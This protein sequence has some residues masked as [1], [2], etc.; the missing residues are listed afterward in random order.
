M[1]PRCWWA[2]VLLVILGTAL[3]QEK[4]SAPTLTRVYPSGVQVGQAAEITFEGTN[5]DEPTGLTTT[6]PAQWEIL[7]GN[8]PTQLR[9]RVTALP[10]AWLGWHLIHVVTKKGVTNGRLF[11]LD[12]LPQVL[13]TGTP[14]SPEQAQAVAPPCV[15]CGV[16][17]KDH[18]H[19][20]RLSV[21]AG[22]RLSF[23]V[24]GRR[25]GSRLDPQLAL[26]DGSGKRQLAFSDDA[27]GQQKDP[28]LHGVF[29]DAGEVL[30]EL[31]DVRYQGGPEA[32]YRLRIG[33]FPLVSG[34]FPLAVERGKTGEVQFVS[35]QG[36]CVAP[37]VVDTAEILKQ[38]KLSATSFMPV[39]TRGPAH[40]P[41]HPLGL[42]SWPAPLRLSAF[43]E[44]VESGT[45][46]SMSSAHEVPVPSGVSGRFTQ[47]ASKRF[48][49][50]QGKKDQ[51]YLLTVTSHAIGLPTT[52][53]LTLLDNQGRTLATSNPTDDPVHI[54]FK[55]PADGVY[56]VQA[57]HLFDAG[58]ASEIFR[59]EIKPVAP[60]F[61]LEAATDHVNLPSG[62]GAALLVTA[63]R[64]LFDGPIE[65]VATE[66]S[67]V[68][69]TI[70]AGQARTFCWLPATLA[71][72][73]RLQ[74]AGRAVGITEGPLA[75]PRFVQCRQVLRQTHNQLRYWPLHLGY[76]LAVQ[77]TPAP[78][79]TLAARYVYPTAVRGLPV[80]VAVTVTR[81]SGVP[82]ELTLSAETWPVP[83]GQPP[84]LAPLRTKIPAD[85]AEAT[86]E[87]H[88][89]PQA[90]NGL[91]V[92]LTGT[93]AA[94]QSLSVLLPGLRF[95]PPFEVTVA[96]P[97]PLSRAG[98]A[99][100]PPPKPDLLL[101]PGWVPG[102]LMCP[103]AWLDEVFWHRWL[104][105]QPVRIQVE[106]QGGYRG[107]IVL[108]V[109]NLPP[110][111]TVDKVTIPEGANSAWVILRSAS[112]VAA[113]Q[114]P[115]VY[116]QGTATGAGNQQQ[117]SAPFTVLVGGEG[118]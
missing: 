57:E 33:D 56:V 19:W 28:R 76:D 14:H 95:G 15:V 5:L 86:I 116:V 1:L 104:G 10:G 100:A 22:Q 112:D 66:N 98:R 89:T 114:K 6:F 101:W 46:D 32:G 69:G 99:A 68:V 42:P 12:E 83:P 103:A 85:R 3:A 31:R 65:I 72:A 111:V 78:P 24:L 64:E 70:P 50:F 67:Q 53:F 84:L 92:V 63:R 60:D 17:D 37:V 81:S 88:P 80:P 8:S 41:R 55:A 91:E 49:R 107:P 117:R 13:T 30:V 44:M 108:E 118:R 113:A 73:P 79:F 59:L 82:E 25:L 11:C 105:L 52:V 34:P 40:L 36:S 18:S 2:S 7:P 110:G 45:N 21:Q 115:D 96:A 43:P 20:F 58:G 27:P 38:N 39:W 94:G 93:N 77:Q 106:R 62:H 87:L 48:Y 16:L 61:H 51:H 47:P 4:T 54:Q 29:T 109:L 102:L 9:M 75:E 97:P 23:E 35:L 90:P 71:K 74:L 26:Y